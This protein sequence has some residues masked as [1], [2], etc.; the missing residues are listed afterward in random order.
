[1]KK[2]ILLGLLI[3]IVFYC[4]GQDSISLSAPRE[5]VERL[6]TPFTIT[7]LSTTRFVVAYVDGNSWES[8]MMIGNIQNDT[9]VVFGNKKIFNSDNSISK[10]EI[11]K[12][13]ETRFLLTYSTDYATRCRIC[14]VQTDN[15][16]Y[17]GNPI[18][19][20]YSTIYQIGQTGI[21]EN[22]FLI[23]YDESDAYDGKCAF[24]ICDNDLNIT[25][26][27]VYEFTNNYLGNGSYVTIDTLSSSRF[28]I[29]YGDSGGKVVAG[30][31][32][33]DDVITFGSTYQFSGIGNDT[34]F[35]NLIGINNDKFAIVYAYYNPSMTGMMTIGSIDQYNQISF[36]HST[37][38]ENITQGI[39]ATKLSS[40]KIMI[41]YVNWGGDNFSYLKTA[42]VG[43]SYPEFSDGTV[44]NELVVLNSEN[45]LTS[46]NSSNFIVSYSDA[47]NFT[48]I[49]R[50][51][52]TN[53]FL[54]TGIIDN[55]KENSCLLYPNPAT[56]IVNIELGDVQGDINAQIIVHDISGKRII[57]KQLNSS[58]TSIDIKNLNRGVY[59]IQVKNGDVLITNRLIVM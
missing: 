5:F 15:F 49:Y 59:I 2:L 45:P 6:S 38:N 41:A 12:L 44:F 27:S 31:I 53:G 13:T 3:S 23:A 7:S 4:G 25:F 40:D 54:H 1:M 43:G 48:G 9:N 55:G 22:K 42:N 30:T 51:G 24:G 50:I 34:Y 37:F 29:A 28:V 35:H 11:S 57:S 19:L 14:E 20:S 33:T 36:I 26:D 8:K 46:L 52:S 47:V 58:K 56:N 39:T 10:I 17:M 21:S 32:S 18:I 16:I